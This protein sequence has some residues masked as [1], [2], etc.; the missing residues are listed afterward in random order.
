[1]HSDKRGLPVHKW[2]YK[3]ISEGETILC[4][5]I[6]TC[7]ECEWED[8]EIYWIKYYK[9]LG[10]ELMNLDKGG[11]GV[12]LKEKR[13][14]DSIQRSIDAHKIPIIALDKK[15]GAFVKKYNSITEAT[16]ELGLKSKS[17]IGNVLSGRSKSSAGYLWVYADEYDETKDYCYSPKSRAMKVYEFDLDGTFIKE[18]PRKNI[19]DEI[20]GYSI[21]GLQFALA[22]KTIY[23]GHYFST[24]QSINIDEYEYY[25]KYYELDNN[26]NVIEEY[27]TL[28]EISKKFGYSTNSVACINI[29]Q[30]KFFPNGNKIYKY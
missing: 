17:A 4:K 30:N 14:K 2:M 26:D 7:P 11:R 21:N 19:F 18:W 16:Q 9:D 8:K 1:M 5:L 22:N 28:E 27:R 23:H 24:E 29:N 13:S 10:Y 15:T 20:E 12:N 6:D 25:Y 3:H